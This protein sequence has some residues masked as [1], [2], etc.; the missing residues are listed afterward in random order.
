M[1]MAGIGN[2]PDLGMCVISGNVELDMMKITAFSGGVVNN[3]NNTQPESAISA[4]PHHL[5]RQ[6]AGR[7]EFM[8]N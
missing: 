6:I 1:K 3:W 5:S 2:L 4:G 8:L 7:P